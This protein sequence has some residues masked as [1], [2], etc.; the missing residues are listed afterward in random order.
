MLHIGCHLSCAKGYLSMGEQALA[1]G[2]DTFQFFTRNPRGGSVKPF[3]RQDADAL[4]ALSVH[5]IEILKRRRGDVLLTPH[6]GEFSRLSGKSAE[7]ILNDPVGSARSF[8]AEHGVTVLL[9][10][11]VSV[12]TDGAR[13]CFNATGSSGM[14]KGGSGDVLSGFI[15]GLAARGLD[16]FSAASVGSWVMGKAGE[17]A[18]KEL[19]AYAMTPSEGIGKVGE[20][21]RSLGREEGER[22]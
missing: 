1:L 7:V 2:A 20:V 6:V 13:V 10:S 21:L 4:N 15:V 14:A 18:E 19:T 17:R 9:K 3:D 12:L 5:G 22:K 16:A 8:A 11:C